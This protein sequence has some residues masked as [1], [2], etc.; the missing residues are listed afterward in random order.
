M[1]PLKSW[2]TESSRVSNEHV[3]D[4]YI[5]SV[6]YVGRKRNA[7]HGRRSY[8]YEGAEA[9]HRAPASAQEFVEGRRGQGSRW[10]IVEVPALVVCGPRRQ[11]V[12][13]EVEAEE[14]LSYV[15]I[16]FGPAPT[17]RDVAGCLMTTHTR[18]RYS[19]R[20]AA[21]RR[22]RA[23]GQ[24]WLS[25]SLPGERRLRWTQG[26]RGERPWLQ[27]VSKASHKRLV[28]HIRNHL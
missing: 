26:E 8:N 23:P 19:L 10:E 14:P 15:R 1:R 4:A 16:D 6:Y 7:W 13:L 18:F 25:Y 2:S 11:I 3:E 28:R 12:A 5:G 17:L 24:W 27:N 20:K 21:F 22:H 9:F